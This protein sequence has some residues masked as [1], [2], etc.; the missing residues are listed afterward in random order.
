MEIYPLLYICCM[1]SLHLLSFLHLA[2]VI[3]N[4]FS[5]P[6]SSIWSYNEIF[7]YVLS[8]SYLLQG[9]G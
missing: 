5:N 6:A 9:G 4:N 7:G 3:C 2:T 8:L 1:V